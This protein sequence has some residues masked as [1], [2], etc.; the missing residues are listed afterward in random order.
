MKGLI[1]KEPWI[2]L[3]LDGKKKWE[4]RGVTTKTRGKILL[5]KSGTGCIWGEATLIDCFRVSIKQL[6]NHYP[7]HRIPIET[8]TTIK[9]HNP[10]AWVLENPKR[11][12]IPIPY[13]HPIGAIIWVNIDSN[14]II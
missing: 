12:D 6:Q 10:C 13:K 1:I 8:V 3:I 4:I 14:D 2:D 9:Y 7:Q 5:I 11:Y